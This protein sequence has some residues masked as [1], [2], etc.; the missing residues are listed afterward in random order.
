MTEERVCCFSGHRPEKLPWGADESAKACLE[1]KN[2]IRLHITRQIE[3]GTTKFLCGMARGTDLYFFDELLAA[4]KNYPITIEAVV[5]CPS[6][7]DRWPA[8]ER[9]RYLRA[10]AECDRVTV[11]EDHY[12]DGCMLRRNRAMIDRSDVLMTVFD[13]SPGGTA[14]AIAYARAKNVEIDAIWL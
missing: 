9:R 2:M 6:Q 4:R 11:L 12:S 7:A 10:L 5:P 13:G 3:K 14:S 1:L 8:G